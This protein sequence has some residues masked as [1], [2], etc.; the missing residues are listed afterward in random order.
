VVADLRAQAK[1]FVLAVVRVALVL[2]LL[3]LVLE[4]AVIH[5]PANGR[6]FLR[7]DFDEIKPSFA[8]TLKRVDGLDDP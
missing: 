4:F 8:G 3:L 2:P 6:L 5:D 1:L 7:G